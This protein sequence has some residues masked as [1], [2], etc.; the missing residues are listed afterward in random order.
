MDIYAFV[1]EIK[2]LVAKN[3]LVEVFQQLQSF[4]KDHPKLDDAI[5]QSGRFKELQQKINKGIISEDDA[6]LQMNQLRSSILDLLN[7]LEGKGSS[8]IIKEAAAKIQIIQ[9]A[10]KIYNIDKIDNANFS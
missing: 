1:K 3:K 5:L 8:P 2:A 7:E 10:D 6:H 4:L 9:K